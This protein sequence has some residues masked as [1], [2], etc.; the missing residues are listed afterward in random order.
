M[1]QTRIRA[2]LLLLPET[3]RKCHHLWE[4]GRGLRWGRS[5]HV[6]PSEFLGEEPPLG[7]NTEV[8]LQITACCTARSVS[9][10]PAIMYAGT[11]TFTFMHIKH[12]HMHQ[13]LL[14]VCEMKWA[15]GR[16]VLFSYREQLRTF[17]KFNSI[18]LSIVLH[19]LHI[20]LVCAL[21]NVLN[22]YQTEW[23]VVGTEEI[24]LSNQ[25]FDIC[26]YGFVH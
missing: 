25:Y 5:N 6:Q 17:H 23:N 12:S 9:S 22:D 15:V 13:H 18:T 7:E 26:V 19:I 24:Q 14:R 8:N 3:Y 11:F 10:F 16:K 1:I 4:W 20:W 2:L 21:R